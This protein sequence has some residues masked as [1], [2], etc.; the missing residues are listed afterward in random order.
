YCD[1]PA[2]ADNA[3]AIGAEGHT[4][5]H[6]LPFEGERFDA[7][8]GIPDLYRPVSAAADDA[9]AIGAE[10]HTLNWP[11]VPLE[12]EGFGTLVGIPDLYSVVKAA[13]DDALAI[14]AEGHAMDPV[15][16]PP[17]RGNLVEACG[18]VVVFPAA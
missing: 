1:V 14:G 8:A 5:D 15:C 2:A 9:L 17:E 10:G 3:F 12:G 16:V 6:A 18:Q 7:R 11:G 4:G 13:A